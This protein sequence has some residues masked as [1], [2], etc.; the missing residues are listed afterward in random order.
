MATSDFRRTEKAEKPDQN[1]AVWL[2][3]CSGLLPG[4]TPRYPFSMTEAT[5]KTMFSQTCSFSVHILPLF[6]LQFKSQRVNAE[7]G[8]DSVQRLPLA[9]NFTW[10][11]HSWHLFASVL[12]IQMNTVQG[13]TGLRPSASKMTIKVKPHISNGL[14]FVLCNVFSCNS[15]SHYLKMYFIATSFAN[16]GNW[17]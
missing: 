10:P 13:L 7:V 2:P 4:I 12:H 9:H 3:V 1:I 5:L 17:F 8:W 16:L 14:Y 15:L 11:M 6:K